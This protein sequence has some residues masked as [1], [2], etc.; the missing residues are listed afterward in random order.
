[1]DIA[2]ITEKKLVRNLCCNL[3]SLIY[4]GFQSMYDESRKKKS[5]YM[6]FFHAFLKDIPNWNDS[7]IEQETQRIKQLYPCLNK[8]LKMIIYI[9]IKTL[10][11]LNQHDMEEVTVEYVKQHTP[12]HTWFIHQV[13]I[14]SAKEFMKTSY[15]NVVDDR[16]LPII[17]R[18]IKFCIMKCVPMQDLLVR[19]ND[20]DNNNYDKDT[21]EIKL[22]E[23]ISTQ[24]MMNNTNED[25]SSLKLSLL[26]NEDKSI[27]DDNNEEEE[28]EE[29][30]TIL[31]E[32]SVNDLEQSL[33]NVINTDHTVCAVDKL[34]DAT[35]NKINM[36]EKK[37]N[38]NPPLN[39]PRGKNINF[40]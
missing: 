24:G 12:K 3:S 28:S 15:N 39:A 40:F 18:N 13:Y 34:Q 20:D 1:M 17:Q 36:I 23:E 31:E 2:S 35:M 11:L 27:D 4:E 26:E 7:M 33:L 37:D 19:V 10:A 8:V 38:K 30:N 5:S 6:V 25:Q 29:E 32:S 16:L 21:L 14:M 9:N 22:N